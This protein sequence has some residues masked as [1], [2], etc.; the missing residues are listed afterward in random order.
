M[1]NGRM[2]PLN[3]EK[4]ETDLGIDFVFSSISRKNK[5]AV[6]ENVTLF[7]FEILSKKG[8]EIPGSRKNEPAKKHVGVKIP[9]GNRKIGFRYLHTHCLHFFGGLAIFNRRSS[10]GNKGCSREKEGSLSMQL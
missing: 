10:L 9:C 4:R 5:S 1:S 7:L 2:L 8:K 6:A 3:P